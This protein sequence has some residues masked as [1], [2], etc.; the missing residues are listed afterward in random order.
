MTLVSTWD[1]DELSLVRE[2][3]QLRAARLI[4]VAAASAALDRALAAA[5]Q[6]GLAVLGAGLYRVIDAGGRAEALAGALRARGVLVRR[7]PGGGLTVAPPLDRAEQAAR[8][9][10]RALPAAIEEAS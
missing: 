6:A 10:E 5:G 2:H 9:I 8:A 3:H 7:F 4:D 1:G